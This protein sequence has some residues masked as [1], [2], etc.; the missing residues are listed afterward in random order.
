MNLDVIIEQRFY[1]CVD[2][3]YWTE[4]SFPYDFWLRY[5][6][7]FESIIIIARVKDIVTP[8][9]GWRRVDGENVSFDALPYYLGP[10]EFVLKLPK[11]IRKLRKLSYESE[12]VILRIPSALSIIY[13]IINLFGAKN[14]FAVEVVGDPEDGFSS[15]ASS[16]SLS[17]FYSFIFAY[18][19]KLLCQ[20]AISSS[21]VTKY[22]L[23]KKY[24]PD[25]S[26]FSTYYSS[27][28]LER[29]QLKFRDSYK[30]KSGRLRL[31][32][33][34]NLSQPYKGADIALEMVN[35]LVKDGL[36]VELQWIGGGGLLS[37]LEQDAKHLGINNRVKFLGN[38]SSRAEINILLDSSDIFIMPSRQEGLP[39]ALIEAMGRGLICVATNVGGI[40]E[41][42]QSSY[43]VQTK[44]YN[45]FA[46]KVQE[47]S[48]MDENSLKE[49]SRI[50]FDKACEY[51]NDILN[52]RRKQ[53][54]ESLAKKS[55]ED[56]N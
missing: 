41:L 35:K 32:A 42:L 23:Q 51:T 50:N 44:D 15:G 9:Q 20:K 16:S 40:P 2:G 38:I 13:F 54:Y 53:M 30:I 43:I 21:Y 27:I 48:V 18:F 33:I 45:Q 31:I 26:A 56:L 12:A 25:P 37:A 17:Y 5:L 36:D 4:N 24:P 34:G 19:Q 39:R 7:T 10:K 46:Q 29:E 1:R 52:L 55:K 11:L 49:Q 6:M 28:F 3:K 47:I 14:K 8:E 22:T